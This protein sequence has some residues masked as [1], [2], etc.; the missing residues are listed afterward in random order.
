M[1]RVNAVVDWIA[2]APSGNADLVMVYFSQPDHN[3]H[4]Y[5][6]DSP[7][8]TDAIASMDFFFGELI[9]GLKAA[10][11][12]AAV[13]V[14]LVADHGMSAISKNRT[15]DL[16]TSSLPAYFAGGSPVT[17]IWPQN[18]RLG[19]AGNAS[20]PQFQAWS[21]E[22]RGPLMQFANLS[23]GHLS[24]YERGSMPA[25]L[26]FTGPLVAPF[27]AVTSPGW[28][29]QSFYPSDNLGAHG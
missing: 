24:I 1:L 27:V 22:M 25:H 20:S 21:A 11:V 23:D 4:L 3:G 15:V 18:W 28:M 29:L 5:G 17:Q 26:H 19:A 8:T 14:V 10:G 16:N 7:E 9:S 2:K 13:D 6:P 12:L